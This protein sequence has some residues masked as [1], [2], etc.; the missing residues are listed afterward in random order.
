MT[1]GTITAL[2]AQAHDPQRVNVFVDGAF[3]L[4]ISLTTVARAG[5]FVGKPLAPDEVAQ[6]EQVEQADR[7]HQVALR[8][9]EARPRSAAE[10]R[11]RLRQKQFPPEVIDPAIARLAEL[12]L[13]D[14]AAFARFWVENRQTC[15]PRGLGALRQ[16]LR[17]KG[18]D[19]Q[20]IDDVLRE[21]VP[22]GDEAD[23]AAT[24]A[25]GVLRRY[26]DAPDRATFMRRLGGYLQRRGFELE[27]IRP[28]VEQL[29]Q[30]VQHPAD[31]E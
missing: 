14:D 7:A 16:E 17:R 21:Q 20:T 5:L 8:Y 26:T 12:G 27:I 31:A 4:G 13:A 6:L 10:I 2:Q 18:L 28:I 11:E 15:R 22:H 3:V 29:W 24:L 1:S 23:R 19:R 30:E 9:L 25:R